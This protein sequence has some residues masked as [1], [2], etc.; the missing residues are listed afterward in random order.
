MLRAKHKSTQFSAHGYSNMAGRSGFSLSNSVVCIQMND[1]AFV[2]MQ[3]YL[4]TYV[5][6]I[7]MQNSFVVTTYPSFTLLYL[8]SLLQPQ[9][10]KGP[11]ITT[12]TIN[13]NNSTSKSS[14]VSSSTTTG[15]TP[16][17]FSNGTTAPVRGPPAAAKVGIGGQSSQQH[18]AATSKLPWLASDSP[19]HKPVHMSDDLLCAVK[20]FSFDTVLIKYN[21][22]FDLIYFK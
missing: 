14:S 20:H 16:S 18:K 12:T 11:T 21:M 1:M 4:S 6:F 22:F 9:W 17:A 8:S 10:L 13:A 5:L 19:V 7:I 2:V 3:C 15:Y